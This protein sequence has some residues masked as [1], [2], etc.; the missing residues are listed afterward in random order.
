M[1]GLVQNLITAAFCPLIFWS[2][3][4]PNTH[5]MAKSLAQA[6]EY[7]VYDKGPDWTNFSYSTPA[8]QD[9]VNDKPVFSNYFTAV[10]RPVVYPPDTGSITNNAYSRVDT[11]YNQGPVYLYDTIPAEDDSRLKPVDTIY[12]NNTVVQ[13]LSA[14]Y[15]GDPNSEYYYLY[16]KVRYRNKIYWTPFTWYWVMHDVTESGRT[17]WIGNFNVYFQPKHE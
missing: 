15:V 2:C 5:A 4:T 13:C 9:E 1:H 16:G 6:K 17:F 11:L 7:I 10:C 3:A 8:L 14:V 12:T